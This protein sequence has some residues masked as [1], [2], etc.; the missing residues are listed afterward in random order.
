MQAGPGCDRV[1]DRCMRFVVFCHSLV[2]DWNHGN[3]HFLR[4]VCSELIARGH[5][6]VAYEPR[7]GWSRANL[8]AEHG[9]A[10]LADFARS[11][12]ELTSTTYDRSSLDLNVVLDGAD[13][14]LTCP[15]S[16][17]H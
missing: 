11:Y 8:E 9:R 7:R 16:P 3:A 10:P 6:V 2:S 12:P 5:E 13:V 15:V 4:G 17:R 14:V 1:P